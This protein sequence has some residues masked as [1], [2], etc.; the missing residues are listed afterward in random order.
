MKGRFRKQMFDRC[1]WTL[2]CQDHWNTIA[3]T[4]KQTNKK[5]ECH[6]VRYAGIQMLGQDNNNAHFNI[7]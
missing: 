7:K 1:W 2:D 4:V 3:F 6:E 5:P